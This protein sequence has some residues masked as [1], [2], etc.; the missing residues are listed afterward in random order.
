MMPAAGIATS[1]PRATAA[2][3][4]VLRGGGNCVDA[5][6]A[7]A[8]VLFVVEPH[9]CGPGGDA[10]LL[11]Q[12]AGHATPVALDGAGA[13]PAGLT[14]DALEAA[15]H[16]RV[17]P[18]GGASVT[19]PGA[20]GMIE[21]AVQRWG[22][23]SLAELAAPAIALAAEGFEVRPTLAAATGSAVRRLAADDVLAELFLTGGEPLA[24]GARVRN[25]ALAAFLDAFAAEGAA[26]L[27]GGAVAEEVA[28]RTRAAGGFLTV[29]DLAAH[30]CDEVAP[31]ST[32]F[33]GVRVWQL[34]APTQGPAVLHALD[35]LA[36][37]EPG[38]WEA[39]AAAVTAGLRAVGVDLVAAPWL[40]RQGGTS[41]VAVVDGAGGA[42]SLITSVFAP[43]GA[44]VGVPALGSA[45][46]NRGAGFLLLDEP[47]RPGK[48]PHTIIPGL[49]TSDGGA[50]A[51]LGVAG[52]LMQAQGQV[53]LLVRLFEEGASAQAAVHAPRFRVVEGGHLAIE[54]G[55]PLAA[56]HPDGLDR[57]PGDGG[58]G[59]GQVALR[60]GG[61]VTAAGDP[62]RDGDAAVVT[63]PDGR[64]RRSE[65]KERGAR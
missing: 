39:V 2:G 6:V 31:A 33:A 10:F 57:P 59:C 45:L 21:A 16:A 5:A 14:P 51:A 41:H 50:V 37:A 3:A 11:A 49:V 29:D 63:A 55:H 65:P 47:P 22:T 56:R 32:S 46:Q 9:H 42:A 52:G 8:L 40:S 58:F 43:F 26:I 13:V 23:R 24:A 64:M 17:P 61:A 4:D 60:T 1:D 7:A 28:A 44:A 48:P 20:P 38:D 12:P 30:G 19:V 53:Q 34:P 18:F 62:R 36:G 35:A 15:G 25:P 27:Y 54:P